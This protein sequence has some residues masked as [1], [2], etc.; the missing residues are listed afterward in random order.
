MFF[1]ETARSQLLDVGVNPA[2]FSV[3]IWNETN[4][5]RQGSNVPKLQRDFSLGKAAQGYANYLAQTNTMGHNADGRDPGARI[6]AAGFKACYWSENVYE[7]W[8]SPGPVAWRDVAAAAMRSW[9]TS[10]VHAANMKAAEARQI[11]VGVAA[12]KHGDRNYYKVVQVFADDCQPRDGTK[13]LGKK[14]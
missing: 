14:P 9:K 2:N 11:G 6:A 1:P 13:S 12:W 10:P 5:F 3:V 8:A 4:A 7:Q